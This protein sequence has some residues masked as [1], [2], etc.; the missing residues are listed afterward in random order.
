MRC[1]GHPTETSE[2]NASSFSCSSFTPRARLIAY[3][4]SLPLYSR[5]RSMVGPRGL[6]FT[7]LW[8][9]F[10]NACLRAVRRLKGLS[11]PPRFRPSSDTRWSAC[12][13]SEEHTS[14]LQ[15]R[16]YLVCRLLLEKKIG[17][18]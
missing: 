14:E 10:R 4:S 6:S 16:Q 5:Q 9:R 11:N 3:S 8:Y 12:P 7:S 1:T 15:S 13:R 17:H 18:P 2:S